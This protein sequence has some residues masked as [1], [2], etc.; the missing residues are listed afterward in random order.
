MRVSFPWPQSQSL[1]KKAVVA[2]IPVQWIV[3]GKISLGKQC[4]SPYDS[5]VI[6]VLSQA[7]LLQY[8]DNQSNHPPLRTTNTYQESSWNPPWLDFQVFDRCA[9]EHQELLRNLKDVDFCDFRFDQLFPACVCFWFGGG[10]PPPLKNQPNEC[11]CFF[12]SPW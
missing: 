8:S 9:Q 5:Q 12:F 7:S 3:L 4:N 1:L 2:E 11:A 6:S 10:G